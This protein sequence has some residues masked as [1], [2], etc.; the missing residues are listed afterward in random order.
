MD[1]AADCVQQRDISATQLSSTIPLKRYQSVSLYVRL[2]LLP[3]ASSV[4]TVYTR[5]RVY[6]TINRAV[7]II[8]SDV[9]P[10]ER[11]ALGSP[12]RRDGEAHKNIFRGKDDDE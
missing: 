6:R 2:A 9:T 8:L 7:G 1:V 4:T 12:D 10:E 11:I 5:G 3:F